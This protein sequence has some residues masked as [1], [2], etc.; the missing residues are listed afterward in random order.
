M[1]VCLGFSW[2]KIFRISVCR[3]VPDG[4][5]ESREL[6]LVG[7]GDFGDS[8]CGFLHGGFFHRLLRPRLIWDSGGSA[9]ARL[10]RLV[11]VLFPQVWDRQS[12]SAL[13][14]ESSSSVDIHLIRVGGGCLCL[15]NPVWYA[16]M[17]R[18]TLLDS[19]GEGGSDL[20]GRR[21][22]GWARDQL[23][24]SSICLGCNTF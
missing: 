11:S 22:A 21:L 20:M 4:G 17:G 1:A 3:Q 6:D 14:E 9:W 18:A 16:L 23:G 7:Y 8:S 13:V 12:G 19:S 2:A 5:F 24:F 15:P 10:P